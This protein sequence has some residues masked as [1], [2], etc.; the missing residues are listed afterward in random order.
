[1]F[2]AMRPFFPNQVFEN[3]N[4][5]RLRNLDREH[6]VRQFVGEDGDALD[7]IMIQ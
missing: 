5:F 6:V 1:M 7:F 2:E 3:A 4:V